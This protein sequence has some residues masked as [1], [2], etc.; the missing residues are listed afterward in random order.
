MKPDTDQ[1]S[2][3]ALNYHLILVIKYRFLS[4]EKPLPPSICVGG[5]NMSPSLMSDWEK[6][7]KFQMKK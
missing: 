5:E 3:F 4:N 6:R 1:H 7:K 2:V